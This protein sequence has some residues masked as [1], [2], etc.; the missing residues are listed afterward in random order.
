MQ[1]FPVSAG[2]CL[3]DPK[4]QAHG[5]RGLNKGQCGYGASMALLKPTLLQGTL[6]CDSAASPRR[7][8]PGPQTDVYLGGRPLIVWSSQPPRRH[9]AVSLSVCCT[10]HGT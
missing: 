7:T 4:A 6:D 9:R 10:Q 8:A 5:E 2:H 1:V 3:A